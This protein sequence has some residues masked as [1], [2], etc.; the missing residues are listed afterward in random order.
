MEQETTFFSVKT[1]YTPEVYQVKDSFYKN[2]KWKLLLILQKDKVITKLHG[3]ILEEECFKD[4]LDLFE[5]NT[6]QLSIPEDFDPHP[7]ETV[8]KYFYLK[9]IPLTTLQNLFLLLKLAYFLK[10]KPLFIQIQEYLLVQINTI[11][12]T[13]DIFKGSLEFSINFQEKEPDFIRKILIESIVFLMKNNKNEEILKNFNAK[14]FQKLNN[15][16]VEQ[17]FEFFLSILKENKASNEIL[18][19]FLFLYRKSLMSY[20]IGQNANFNKQKYYQTFIEK[21]VDLSNLDMKNIAEY[22][23]KLEVDENFEMKDLMISAM[24]DNIANNKKRINELENKIRI[25]EENV[26]QK[27]KKEEEERLILKKAVYLLDEYKFCPESIKNNCFALSNSNTTVEKTISDSWAGIRCNERTL[28]RSLN[29]KIFSIKIEKTKYSNIL[30]GFCVK[31]ADNSNCGYHQTTSS[32][33]L[34]LAGGYIRSRSSLSDY[35]NKNNNNKYQPA[36]INQIYTTILDIK[37][38]QMAF[39]KDGILM[40]EPK[41]IDL[42]LEEIDLL[43]PCVDLSGQGDKV[44]LVHAEIE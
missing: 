14:Y 7:I 24:R 18:M 21:Y 32:F 33:M 4:T 1:P 17:T 15:T 22:I 9:E 19:E 5:S 10:V 16:N 12:K 6:N 30:I 38:S 41:K 40:G 35:L 20:F 26:L 2:N 36:Q 11:S 8:V 27:L 23:R 44:T 13:L 31:T 29:K 42:K 28:L 3:D 37:E 43:C 34:S 25:L 39:M